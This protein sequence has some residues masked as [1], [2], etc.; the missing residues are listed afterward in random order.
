[1]SL[2]PLPEVETFIRE[3]YL[4]QV[5]YAS[6]FN[7]PMGVVREIEFRPIEGLPEGYTGTQWCAVAKVLFVTGI[8]LEVLVVSL[9]LVKNVSIVDV[10][11]QIKP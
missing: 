2:Q 9:D 8:E 7:S 3:R 4:N 11:A 5:V 10:L 6:S 1:M